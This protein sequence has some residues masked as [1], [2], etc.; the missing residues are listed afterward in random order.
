MLSISGTIS[1]NGNLL[2]EGTVEV[3]YANG[4]YDQTV[5][6]NSNGTF[7]IKSLC[8]TEYVLKAIPGGVDEWSYLPTY[9]DDA[10]NFDDA[11]TINMLANV[12]E[13]NIDLIPF[14]GINDQQLNEELI[15]I[16]PNPTNGNFV[17]D[18]GEQKD[19]TTIT[20]STIIGGKIAESTHT[21]SQLIDLTLNA[22][23]GLYLITIIS[24]GQQATYKLVKE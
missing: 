1:G 24:N 22:P 3:Y 21:Q 14:V 9:Y 13:L 16:Y 2:T 11:Y 17:V 4:D 23:Q 6:V 5:S 7:K 20:I 10:D 12:I 15:S 18:L 8:E 19:E